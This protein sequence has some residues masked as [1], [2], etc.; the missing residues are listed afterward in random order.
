MHLHA[1]VMP[2]GN[3]EC[4]VVHGPHNGPPPKYAFILCHGY[5]APGDDLVGLTNAFVQALPRIANDAILIFPKAPIVLGQDFY[6]ESRA[7]WPI[8]VE[9]LER[10]IQQ[11]EARIH[12]DEVPADLPQRREDFETLLEAVQEGWGLSIEQCVIGGFSQGAMLALD[13]ALHANMSPLALVLFSSTLLCEN[14]WR[15]H[16]G[17]L[18]GTPVFQSHGRQ[19]P[20]LRFEEAEALRDLLKSGGADVTFTAFDG[21][22]EIGQTAMEAACGLL[23]RVL[24]R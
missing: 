11:G 17:E 6:G 7:W 23:D 8:D 10:S 4:T 24:Q 13:V 12:R 15:A 19:D 5:G 22:H 1:H 21:Q 2:L 20:L 14:E 16:A 9:A 18:N 3:L